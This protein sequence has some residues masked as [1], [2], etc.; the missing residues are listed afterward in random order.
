[1]D[2]ERPAPGDEGEDE[3][4]R[5]RRKHRAASLRGPVPGR[6]GMTLGQLADE[7]LAASTITGGNDGVAQFLADGGHSPE[8]I[9]RILR[10]L[11][12]DRADASRRDAVVSTSI[13][14]T[15]GQIRFR[16]LAQLEALLRSD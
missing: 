11:D 13:T 2:S 3:V 14:P 16:T 8:T 7:A 6:P 4:A 1:M 9:E 10:C 15:P 5:Q 12:L